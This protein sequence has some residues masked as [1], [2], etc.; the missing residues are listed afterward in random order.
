MDTLVDN[1]HSLHTTRLADQNRENRRTFLRRLFPQKPTFREFQSQNPDLLPRERV[2][3][4]KTMSRRILLQKAALSG[5]GLITAAA[6]GKLGFDRIANAQE[7]EHKPVIAEPLQPPA[8]NIKEAIFKPDLAN[9]ILK[10][11]PGS[12]ERLKSEKEYSQEAIKK[13]NETKDIR[14]IDEAF[15]FIVNTEE[16]IRLLEER[17]KARESGEFG[18]RQLSE[19]E[20]KFAAANKFHTEWIAICVDSWL[21]T[22]DILQKKIK[23]EKGMANFIK[24]Y[25]PDLEGLVDPKTIQLEDLMLPIG[26]LIGIAWHESKASRN[27]LIHGLADIG[28]LPAI[29]NLKPGQDGDIEK[30]KQKFLG[31]FR[32]LS[33]QSIQYPPEKI[34]G[35]YTGD[36]GS[37]Q[38][39]PD[40]AYDFN[41]F[42]Q[43]HFGFKFNLFGL[44]AVTAACL[45][46]SIGQKWENK[47]G[48]EE[49]RLGVINGKEPWKINHSKT[50]MQRWNQ[51]SGDD[52]LEWAKKY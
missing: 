20:K 25:R 42:F 19:K 22:R 40:T 31:L 11:D 14:Y 29:N 38:F 50:A 36:M 51:K 10:L 7:E 45:M 30:V 41:I 13:A 8:K 1:E 4:Y 9:S 17:G 5:L 27:G 28:R 21:E 2:E 47:E 52:I 35:S 43:K 12:P 37:V 33:N 48:K 24:A 15:E 18:L 3:K 44:E 23:D 16:R 26:S 46:L 49:Y 32:L 6:L 34:P 39:R